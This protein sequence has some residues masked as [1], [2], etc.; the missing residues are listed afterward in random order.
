[1]QH[2]AD[3]WLELKSASSL[4]FVNKSKL[5]VMAWRARARD[6]PPESVGLGAKGN[7]RN[8]LGGNGACHTVTCSNREMEAKT[9]NKQS[10]DQITR[11]VERAFPG[12][13]VLETDDAIMEMT[14]G[15]FN[16]SYGVSLD[17]GRRVVL[18]IA[19]PADAEVMT[20]E[21]NMMATEV[22]TMQRVKLNPAIPAPEILFFDTSHELCDAHYFFMEWARGDN[23]GHVKDRLPPEVEARIDHHTGQIIRAI[24]DFKG[25]YFGF[26]GNEA[27]Q[28]NTWSCLLY[29][30]PSPR[31]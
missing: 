1:M 6:A 24:N 27:L 29:T 20:Y 7:Q 5:N 3:L 19:P 13:S 15:W 4:R 30:S 21:Q 8:L 9:K 23:L 28:A 11:M 22:A 14:D 18:K 16:A 17:D 2:S 12:L 31:D 10:R 26:E 25:T